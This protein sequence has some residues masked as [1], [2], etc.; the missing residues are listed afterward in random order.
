[1]SQST[2]PRADSPHD[3]RDQPRF[4]GELVLGGHVRER[5]SGRV[6]WLLAGGAAVVTTLSAAVATVP[7]FAREDQLTV[8]LPLLVWVAAPGIGPAA[9][10]AGEVAR[11][12]RS[13]FGVW[14]TLPYAAVLFASAGVAGIEWPAWVAPA[15]GLAAAVPFALLSRDPDAVP[16]L[17]PQRGAVVPRG[18]L[19]TGVA[20]MVSVLAAGS[21]RDLWGA[22]AQVVL[23][24]ALGCVAL[25]TTGLAGAASR[26]R[27]RHW[28]ALVWGTLV[29]WACIALRAAGGPFAAYPWLGVLAALVAGTPLVRLGLRR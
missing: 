25:R 15:V 21:D 17:V 16:R 22:V 20:V 11:S 6:P 29:A 7:L 23:L 9:T 19:L 5:A 3:D 12:W 28:L 14:F 10:W 27:P 8:F 18:T 24:V 2:L 26:W 4:E 1:M 13:A